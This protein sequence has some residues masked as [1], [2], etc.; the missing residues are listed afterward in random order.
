MLLAFEVCCLLVTLFTILAY[1][2]HPIASKEHRLLPLY[3]GIIAVFDFYRIVLIITG[4]ISIFHLLENML[5]LTLTTVTSFYAMDY[6]QLRQPRMLHAGLF[7]YLLVLLLMSFAGMG[8]TDIYVFLFRLFTDLNSTFIF[9]SG[10]ISLW[11]KKFT[12]QIRKTNTLVFIAI[13]IPS[14]A[15]ATWQVRTDKGHFLFLVICFFSCLLIQFLIFSN[16]LIATDIVLQQNAFADAAVAQFLF[17]AN[18]ELIAANSKAQ[19][20]FLDGKTFRDVE[21]I[22]QFFLTHKELIYKEKGGVGEYLYRGRVYESRE[23]SSYQ[24]TKVIGHIFTVNDVTEERQEMERLEEQKKEAQLQTDLKSRMLANM[25]HDL[26]SPVHAIIGA[27]DVLMANPVISAKN[28]TLV[29]YVRSSGEML[30]DKINQILLYSKMEAGRLELEEHEYSLEQ[31]VLEQMQMLL[32]NLHGRQIAYSATFLTPIPQTVLG[33]EN[34]VREVMQNLLA[35]SVKY[36]SSG[37]IRML[38]SAELLDDDAVRFTCGVEDTGCGMTAEQQAHIFDDYVTYAIDGKEG[39]GLGMTIVKQLCDLMQG[40]CSVESMP[41]EGTTVTVRFLHHR[42]GDGMVQP[43]DINQRSMAQKIVHYS[44]DVQPEHTF[45]EAHVLLADDMVINQQIFANIIRPWK[46]HLD[47]VSDGRE[48]VEAVHRKSYDLIFLDYLMPEQNGLE[49]GIEIRNA[50]AAPMILLTAN[51]QDDMMQAAKENG[52]AG[53]LGKP[54]DMKQFKQYMEQLLPHQLAVPVLK[55]EYE[56]LLYRTQAYCRTLQSYLEEMEE[57]SRV[58]P[59]YAE[60]DLAMFR[61]KIHGVKGASRQMMKI[62]LSEYAET[63]EMAA[64]LDNR[65]YIERHMEGFLRMMDEVLDEVRTELSCMQEVP[66]TEKTVEEKQPLER[67]KMQE[68]WQALLEA[69]ATYDTGQIEHRLGTIG[70]MALSEEEQHVYEQLEACLKD[71]AYEEGY[72]CL[73]KYLG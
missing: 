63:L 51:D 41:G 7:V 53:F 65:K 4:D 27:S 52:F 46:V 23:S 17:D 45:P 68:L 10:L 72:D 22:H 37:A 9:I 64:I 29:S 26:R 44:D 61:S 48:A 6:L 57:L 69:F 1:I 16:Q 8:D 2:E 66:R 71:F 55:S 47:I 13:F 50:T 3:L 35:N 67:E 73:K 5:I 34:R 38:I 15:G 70:Q 21:D 56:S 62:A 49:A 40:D 30:L 12:Y 43:T 58:L 20:I 24:G 11:K 33:D 14:L 18:Y 31:L 25:S 32:Y 60:G 42:V 36:T 59:E 54:I 19:A 39:T 28:R